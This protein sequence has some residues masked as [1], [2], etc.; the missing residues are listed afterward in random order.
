MNPIVA[1]LGWGAVQNFLLTSGT[2]PD[3]EVELRCHAKLK[4]FESFFPAVLPHETDV[5]VSVSDSGRTPRGTCDDIVKLLPPPSP[6]FRGVRRWAVGVTT[7]PRRQ[8]TLE[9]CLNSLVAAGWPLPELFVDG[10][11]DIPAA[12]QQLP[13]TRR[14][15]QFGARGNYYH[16]IKDLL[17]NHPE[18]EAFMLVQDDCI[19][20]IELSVREY[21]ERSLWPTDG[22]CL[23]SAWCCADDTAPNSGWNEYSG[24]WRFGAVTFIF[25]RMTAERFVADGH[26]Q[27][28]FLA[29][30]AALGGI[31]GLLGEW[32]SANNIP[33]FFPTPSLVQHIGDISTIWENAR[34]VGVRRAKRFIGDEWQA[35]H[36]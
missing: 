13:Q 12:L 24:K 7:S 34:A 1:S 5:P 30:N 22:D 9:Q 20:P 2:E 32:A 25:P 19:W 11:A 21:L 15:P 3:V 16:T 4:W 10:E 14:T 27:D 6:S 29:E 8:D 18:A 33:V 35:Q 26:I 36:S 31:S 23:V 28:A 17:A